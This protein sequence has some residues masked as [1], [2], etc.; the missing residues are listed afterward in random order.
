MKANT[1]FILITIVLL[2]IGGAF[3]SNFR[4]KT[5]A[6]VQLVEKGTIRNSVTGNVNVFPESSFQLRAENQG[7]A[8]FV[9]MKPLGKPVTVS[10]EEIL[11]QLDNSDLNRSLE[12]A[13]NAQKTHLDRIELGSAISLQLEI[14][15][16]ELESLQVLAKEDKVPAFELQKKQNLVNRL[17]LQLQNEELEWE[18]SRKNH[19]FKIASLESN[20]EKNAIRS[21]INGKLVSSSVTPG[22]MVFAGTV[23][24][25]VI[26]HNRLIEVTLNEEE[27]NGIKEGQPA[28]VTLYTFGKRIF[29]ANV[30]RLSATIEPNTGRRKLYLS[31]ATGIELPTGGAGRAEIIKGIQENTLIIPR[32]A[33][34]GNSV[35]V[36]Q[37]G[38]VSIRKV[39]IGAS[40][41]KDVEI[42]EGLKANEQV[43]VKTPHLFE[44]NQAVS[45]SVIK[46]SE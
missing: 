26:S 13:H 3:W 21:P 17:T 27:F 5:N 12:Q 29:D 33:L 10:K 1:K 23:I 4:F 14:E 41:L 32:K 16:K 28:A 31:I 45:V 25:R 7:K 24:G 38:V 9:L 6:I 46:P 2:C 19:E 30:S 34:L 20:I 11:L 37:N 44:N 35:M 8:Q 39:T 40:N 18:E 43:I 22:E 36:V 42:I 15:K